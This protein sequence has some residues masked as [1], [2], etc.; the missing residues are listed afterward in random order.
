MRRA[1]MEELAALLE[2]KARRLEAN[3]YRSIFATLYGWQR[4]FI[5]HWWR[6]P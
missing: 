6:R 5:A 4:E 1:E 2:E 3:R